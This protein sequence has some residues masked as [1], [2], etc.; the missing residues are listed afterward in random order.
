MATKKSNKTSHVL[1]LITNRTGLTAEE[2]EQGILLEKDSSSEQNF[3]PERISVAIPIERIVE[4]AGDTFSE[5]FEQIIDNSEKF[6]QIIDDAVSRRIDDAVSKK[7]DDVVEVASKE[8]GAA[9]SAAAKKTGAEA[10]NAAKKTGAAENAAKKRTADS[11]SDKIA[12]AISDQIRISLEKIESQESEARELAKKTRMEE[13]AA[14]SMERLTKDVTPAVEAAK[15]SAPRIESYA[16]EQFD[17]PAVAANAS[18]EEGAAVN[19][20]QAAGAQPQTAAVPQAATATQTPQA[21]PQAD[22]S[23]PQ[24]AATQQ[25]APAQAAAPDANTAPEAAKAEAHHADDHKEPHKDRDFIDSGKSMEGLILTN[26]LEEVMRLEAPVIM[27]ELEM[28][29]CDRCLNDVLAIAL[30]SIP[31]KYVVSKRGALFAKIASYGNQYKTDIYS[32]LTQACV[33]VKQSPSHT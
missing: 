20:A 17:Q 7:I 31:P 11:A 25:Q 16:P 28:C 32:R 24:A 27:A 15:T 19:G 14:M 1:N 33:M 6:E 3:S 26:I 2:I 30:N 22:P 5:K 13:D 29:C 12:D 8:T 9:A 18:Q 23:T 21:A 4:Q 10:E